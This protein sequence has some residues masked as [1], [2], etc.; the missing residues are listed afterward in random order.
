MN[1][2]IEFQ[3]EMEM[4]FH[5]NQLFPRIKQEFLN[6]REELEEV[7]LKHKLPRDFAYD[8]LTQ[9]VLHKRTIIDILVG[10]LRKHFVRDKCD[11]CQECA[12]A[13]LEAS[14]ANLIDY[15]IDTRQVIVRFD[16][17]QDVQDELDRYQY[18]LPMVVKPLVLQNNMDS[19]YY[20]HKGSV[21]LKKN[22]HN[23]D[24]CLDHLNRMNQIKLKINPD[25]AMTIKNR[26]RNLDK[27]KPDE[28]RK[29]FEKRQRAFEKFD[30]TAHD[31]LMHLGISRGEEFWLTHRVD[32]RGR[33]YSQGYVV[34]YQGNT[35]Q[36]A[37]IAFANEEVTQ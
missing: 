19:G 28:E 29:D 26:W 31:V 11:G 22:H 36:K 30:R 7:F 16:I 2:M 23:E 12:D 18:P 1:R 32:K 13:I 33:T 10:I 17:S 14:R 27:P 20:T 8:L 9:M 25:V 5:K 4:L 21:I 6:H 3:K 35:W 15:Q 24:V 37:C 34:N